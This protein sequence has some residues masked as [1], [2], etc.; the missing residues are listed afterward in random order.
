[1]VG[2]RLKEGVELHILA[3]QAGIEGGWVGGR[4]AQVV[5]ACEQAVERF[6]S[7]GAVVLERE[8]GGEGG[9]GRTRVVLTDPV[10]FLLSNEII[11]EI[12]AAV[13]ILFE[14]WEKGDEGGREGGREE[15]ATSTRYSKIKM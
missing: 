10:G 4:A 7:M 8:G 13:E 11:S 6:I 14:G 3:Q 15:S 5:L 12:F 9:S 2:L 1:M